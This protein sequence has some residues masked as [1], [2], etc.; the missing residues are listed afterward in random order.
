ML[1]H[2]LTEGQK[3]GWNAEYAGYLPESPNWVA[4]VYQWP[5]PWVAE[6]KRILMKYDLWDRSFRIRPS[7]VY[8]PRSP[9]AKDLPTM[10]H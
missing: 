3:F 9:W 7:L 4:K 5:K 6:V 2:F 1:A 10:G 8:P